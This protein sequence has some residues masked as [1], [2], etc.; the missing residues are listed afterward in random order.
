MSLH[1]CA[2]IIVIYDKYAQAHKHTDRLIGHDELL[3]PLL[4]VSVSFERA[5]QA[6][7]LCSA[8]AECTNT[9]RS[10]YIRRY[11]V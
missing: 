2:L 6:S 9:L 4:I 10:T 8:I 11:N 1:T 3:H 7:R 5:V